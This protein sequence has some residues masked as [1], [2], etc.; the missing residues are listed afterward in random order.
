MKDKNKFELIWTIC[1]FVFITALCFIF[2]SG[3]PLWLLFIW[4]LGF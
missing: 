4:V 1:W 3:W 2:Q